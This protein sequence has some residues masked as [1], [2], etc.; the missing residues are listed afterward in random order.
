MSKLLIVS[1]RLKVGKGGISTALLGFVQSKAFEDISFVKIT[2]HEDG[3]ILTSL[4]SSFISILLRCNRNDSAWFHCGPWLSMFRKFILAIIV[5]AKG[6]KVY[7]HMHS[8][9]LANYLDSGKARKWL[10]LFFSIS[11]G[12]IVLTPWWRDRI[13]SEFPQ[14]VEK[15]QVTPNPL[16][17]AFTELS[18]QKRKPS[19]ARANIKILSMARLAK[20]KGFEYV[21]QAMPLLPRHYTLSIAGDGMLRPQLEKLVNELDLSSRVEF[22]GWVDYEEKIK[23]L[24]EHDI[25]C[26]PSRYDSF[27]M[28]Y[29]EAMSAGVPVIALDIDSIPYVV[30]NEKAGILVKNEQAEL[31]SLAI[32]EC[33]KNMDSFGLY[34]KKFVQANFDKENMSKKIINFMGLSESNGNR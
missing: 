22:L 20:G 32:E 12:V 28:G 23:L 33:V 18:K 25:F 29:I 26:L 31:I 13:L 14:L 3:K 7:F 2:S 24:S 27:G 30:P 6:G 16:D 9:T 1:T 5:K 11:D 17:C 10:M 19:P 34:G 8:P 4:M 21:I 15:L